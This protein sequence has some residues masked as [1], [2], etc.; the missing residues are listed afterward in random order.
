[1]DKLRALGYFANLASTLNFST[2]AEHFGVPSSSVSRRIKDLEAELGATLFERTTRTVK[3]TDLGKVYLREISSALQSIEMA[4]ELVGSQSKSPTG[5]LRITAMPAYGE[6]FVMP[7]IEKLHLLYNDIDFDLNF[8]DQVINLA[9]NDADIAIRSVSTL[10]DS[11][12][13]RR[14]CDH[15][16][17]L[18]ASPDYI[19][20]LGA[21]ATSTDLTNRKVFMYRTPHGTLDWLVRHEDGW[22]ALN[23]NPK[24]V[25]NYGRS[26]LD[27]VLAG[28]GLALLPNWGVAQDIKAGRLSV[29]ELDDGPLSTRGTN[30]QGMYLLYHPPKYRLQKIR[31]AVDFLVAE[32]KVDQAL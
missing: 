32:L 1:M 19:A 22:Q 2:T 6:R 20:K 12:V 13:A 16:F 15:Y 7:A 25:S 3:L 8:T 18:V 26:I 28:R 30:G 31:V 14:L 29:I 27:N 4:D 23:L 5:K 10:P 9:S 17:V 11:T 24:F 21:P